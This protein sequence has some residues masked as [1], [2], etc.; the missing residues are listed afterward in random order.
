MRKPLALI[1]AGSLVLAGCGGWRDSRVNPT[2]WFGKSRSVPVA[3]EVGEEVNPL[4]PEKQRRGIFAPK[5]TEDT[6]VLVGEI[7]ALRIEPTPT[8]AIVRATG[9]AERQGAHKL[10]LRQ[11]SDSAAGT[12][13]FDFRVLYPDATTPTG[14]IHSRTIHAAVTLSKQDLAGIRV[15]RVSGATNARD[16]RRR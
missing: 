4:I 5:E 15:I 13:E 8:G 16:S 3:A 6:S 11:V 7:S 2:N 9:V 14:S 12:L 1:L 10:E